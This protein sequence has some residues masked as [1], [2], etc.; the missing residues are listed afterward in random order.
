MNYEYSVNIAWSEE[1]GTYLATIRELPGCMSDGETREEALANVKQI[2]AEWI[3]VAT[4][5]GREIPKPWSVEDYVRS[6]QESRRTAKRAF[7]N[8]LDRAVHGVIKKA[9]RV[10][11][12]TAETDADVWTSDP[13]EISLNVP[14]RR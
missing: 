3:E 14:Q 5:E 4:E 7:K 13:K 8:E 1:D 2:A 6:N 12:E 9:E 11:A 10:I